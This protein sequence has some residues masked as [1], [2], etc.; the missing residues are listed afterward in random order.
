SAAGSWSSPRREGAH[1]VRLHH[2]I[3]LP[4]GPDAAW[5]LLMD[6]PRVATC[7]PGAG[8]VEATGPDRYAGVLNVRVGPVALALRGE[9]EVTG[10]D[11]AERHASM[12]VDAADR[13]I[14]GMVQATMDMRLSGDGAAEGVTH[15]AIDT[16][17]RILGRLG[18]FG[19]PVIRKKAD[20]IV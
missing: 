18:D 19:Q 4:A 13:R 1:G 14:G 12:R 9:V 10:R 8:P 7:V 3:D 16:D 17:A 20:Q 15:L 2:E 11:A 6:V 5:A